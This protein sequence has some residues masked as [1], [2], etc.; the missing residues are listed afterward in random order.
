MYELSAPPYNP[1]AVNDTRSLSPEQ[2]RREQLR[3]SA[4]REG[5]L[6]EVVTVCPETGRKTRE[7]VGAKSAWMDQYKS[8]GRLMIRI[9]KDP[10][11]SP[12][13]MANGGRS[14]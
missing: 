8:P 1:Y 9:N 11:P 3:A 12:F 5:K 10:A 13:R 14:K 7:Y 6:V 2:R 4:L